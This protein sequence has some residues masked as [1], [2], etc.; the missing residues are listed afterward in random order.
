MTHYM[1]LCS[2]PFNSIKNK[3]KI[4]ELRLLDPKRQKLKVGDTITFTNLVTLL[5]QQQV[6]VRQLFLLLIIEIL[7][8]IIRENLVDCYLLHIEKK[9]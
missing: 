2:E 6:Q 4:Y 9:F 5:L 3:E 1:N 7:E 8:E